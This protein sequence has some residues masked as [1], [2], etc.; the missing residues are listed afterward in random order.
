M[1]QIPH[2]DPLV[3]VTRSMVEALERLKVPEGDFEPVGQAS[4]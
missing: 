2:D 3:H 4:N 1:Y